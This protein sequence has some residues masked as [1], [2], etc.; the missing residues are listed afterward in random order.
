MDAGTISGV[1]TAVL[2]VAFIGVVIWAYSRRRK[3]DFEA[4]A[5]QAL[6][7]GDEK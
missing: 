3:S 5:R 6:K 7:D 4:A 2:L 1:I